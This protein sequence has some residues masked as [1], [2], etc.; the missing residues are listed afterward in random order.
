MLP[1]LKEKLSGT[2][3]CL[4]NLKS[5]F[6]IDIIKDLFKNLC[7]NFVRRIQRYVLKGN[8]RKVL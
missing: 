3:L 2:L 7:S 4:I 5:L 1:I 6:L 8:D